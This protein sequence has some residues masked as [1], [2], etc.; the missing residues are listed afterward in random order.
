[1]EKMHTIENLI[2]TAGGIAPLAREIGSSRRAIYDWVA[3][4]PKAELAQPWLDALKFRR[5]E[6]FKG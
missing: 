2:K 4:D 5:P 1:M 6:W 3:E